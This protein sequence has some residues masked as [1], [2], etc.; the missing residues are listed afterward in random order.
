MPAPKTPE[1][2]RHIGDT[3]TLA[4]TQKRL[5]GL[6]H[7]TAVQVV[8]KARTYTWQAIDKIF[9]LM[10]GKA[11]QITVLDKN[12]NLV[13]VDVEVPASVQM[14][15]AEV[16]LERGWGKSPQAIMLKTDSPLNLNEGD[17]RRFTVQEKIKMLLQAKIGES[18]K[19]MDLEASEIR[20]EKPEP[21]P[22]EAVIEEEDDVLALI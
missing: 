6:S 17:D 8:Q 9:E 21:R 20:E 7:Q 18:D 3:S 19:A 22:V 16:L 2:L 4:L 5:A 11:G 14:K 12:G 1:G 13:V 15:A 10:S